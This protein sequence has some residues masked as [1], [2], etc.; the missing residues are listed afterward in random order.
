MKK[1][2][3]VVIAQQPEAEAL[4]ELQKSAGE[5]GCV[6]VQA[7]DVVNLT[8]KVRLWERILW[9]ALVSLLVLG[10]ACNGSLVVLAGHH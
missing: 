3:P 1:G 8:S 9:I 5:R 6:I 2:R 4:Q 7:S 10:N